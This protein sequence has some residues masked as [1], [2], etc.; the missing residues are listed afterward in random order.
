MSES[1][2]TK[3]VRV[4]IFDGEDESFQKW[5]IRFRAYAKISGFTK[6]IETDPEPDLP[7]SQREVD[8]LSGNGDET[9]KKRA[10]ADRNDT[11]MASLTLAFTTDDL[12][13][14][15]MQSQTADWPDGLASNVVKLL[16][17]KY[18]PD[19]IMSLVDEKMAL[20]KIRMGENEHPTKLFDRIKAVETRFNTKTNK[21]KEEELIAVVLSQAPKAYRAVLTSEQR[22][23]KNLG[24][25]VKVK[26]L[27]E[28][29][30]EHFKLLNGSEDNDDE[31]ALYSN[32]NEKKG[33]GRNRR[34]KKFNGTCN[35][36]GTHGHKAKECW[37][38]DRNADKRPKWWKNKVRG[39]ETNAVGVDG[40]PEIV[41]TA[42]NKDDDETNIDYTVDKYTPPKLEMYPSDDESEDEMPMLYEREAETDDVSESW[43]TQCETED[44]SE[45]ISSDDTSTP[46]PPIV[47]RSWGDESTA[48]ETGEMP[49]MIRRRDESTNSLAEWDDSTIASIDNEYEHEYHNSQG[50]KVLNDPVV[51]FGDDENKETALSNLEIP[52]DFK[53]LSNPDVWIADTGATVHNTPHSEGIVNLQTTDSRDSVT[54][55]NG[56]KMESTAIGNIQGTITNKMGHPLMSVTL[57]DVVHTPSSRFNLLSLT[58][59]MNEGWQ[60]KGNKNNLSIEKNGQS[61]NFDIVVP[62]R[63]GRLFCV[64]IQRNGEINTL[65]VEISKDKAHKVLGHAGNEATVATAKAL[66]WKLTG[67]SHPCSSCGMAKAKQKAVPKTSNHVKA[68]QPGERIFIDL[69]KIKKPE[70]LKSMGKQN[71]YMIVDEKS[72]LKFSS[73]HQTKNE[74]ANYTC[75]MLNKWKDS[76]IVTKYCRCDNA[77]ENKTLEKTANGSKWRFNIQFEYT[78]RATPQQ[79][80]PVETGFAHILNKARAMMIDANIPYLQRYKIIQEA[81][82]T[83]TKLDGLVTVNDGKECKTRY[84]LFGLAVP[85]FVKYLRTWGEAGVVKV[86]TKTSPKLKNKGVTCIFVGYADNHAGDCYRMWEPIKHFIYI[87]RD[88]LWLKRMYYPSS[89]KPS[90]E[91]PIYRTIEAPNSAAGENHNENENENETAEQTNEP[92]PPPIPS[93]LKVTI[94]GAT[95]QPTDAD[96]EEE[97]EQPP[98]EQP[99]KEVGIRRSRTGRTIH[100]V[101]LYQN[102][103]QGVCTDNYYS[104]LSEDDTEDYDENEAIYETVL[105][106]ETANVGAGIGGGFD[107]SNELKVLNY[108]QAMASNEK[109]EWMKEIEKEHERMMKYNV[110]EPVNREDVPEVKPLTSTWAFKK[111]STGKRRGRLNAHGFK[112]KPG[113]H[114][115]KDSISSPVTNEVTIRIVLVIIILLQLLAGVLDVKGAFLQGNFDDDEEPIYMEVPDGLEDK[116]DEN[117]VLKLLAPIYGLRNASMAFYKKLKKCMKMIGCMRSLADPCLYFAWAS[118]LMIWLSWIDDCL[119]CGKPED[120]AHYKQ[121]L[122]IKLDCDDAGELKEYVG[123]KIERKGNRMKLTQP[124]LVQSLE[125]E[126]EIPDK[127]PCNLPAPHGKEL[128]SDGE[129]LSDEE[130]KVYRSG[131]GKLL[132]LMRYSRPDILNAVR[133]LSKWM[134]DG[135]TIDHMKVMRQTMNYVIHTK[136]RGL[137]LQPDM[138]IKDPKVDYFTIKGRSDSNYAT[139]VETRKSVSGLEVL[140]NGAPV[141]MR[142]IGQ[143][144]IALS[145][146]E[147]E[148]IAL[149]QVVQEMLYVMRILESMHL[150]VAKPMIVESDNKGAIDLCNS[151]TVGGRTK[152][153]D[154]RYYFLREL[155]EEGVLIFNWISGKINSTDMFTKNLPNPLFTKHAGY[156]CTDEDFAVGE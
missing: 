109:A 122:M 1:N 113:V 24:I 75:I 127:T 26:D 116:Y 143:K 106:M 19:G 49:M 11:A 4:P 100:P 56:N 149:A 132:F 15:I 62:T 93:K 147:A 35:N 57:K 135:A 76:G 73:F 83:A 136:N 114:F 108:K 90:N 86:H 37:A 129:P 68:E 47:A 44:E 97:W 42:I 105:G 2:D 80:S 137:C 60:L 89:N 70:E 103:Y 72:N 67:T 63:R 18:K 120:V 3:T 8:A 81:I 53:V 54:V 55:G 150:K 69:S 123:C 48:D 52:A 61:I 38:L 99:F 28:V 110:W 50:E 128:T 78:A 85:S 111:K 36:C 82:I 29:M 45:S 155:K 156:Y 101:K 64:N 102:E 92:P 154:T 66:G 5:W 144:I 87:T 22:M 96:D 112:Q 43:G 27:K 115:K 16:L 94:G 141:V 25:D 65:A 79:N 124:V 138:R 21:I 151:W 133:E 88:V 142:S 117:I 39:V 71:W 119:Y 104:I 14:I 12:I 95:V 126:F 130:K 98:V 139:N 17:D 148:L 152:H 9:K 91:P 32:L 41:L 33:K 134:S 118:G 34:K 6:A 74:I 10:A 121:E 58:R 145:V 23:R 131:V 146:T 30:V 84:E 20:N 46:P 140:L 59:L 77:G 125:D 107:H 13:N 51:I 31:I 40:P 7:G 153:I